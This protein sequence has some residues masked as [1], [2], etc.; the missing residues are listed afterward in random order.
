MLSTVTPIK[1]GTMLDI[2]FDVQSL[3]GHRTKLLFQSEYGTTVLVPFLIDQK[4][5][6]E[7]T[8]ERLIA[9]TLRQLIDPDY[10]P[11]YAL[12]V[13]EFFDLLKDGPTVI[14]KEIKRLIQ[15]AQ[16]KL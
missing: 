15:T 10:I 2:G 13:S 1:T 3:F 4:W 11:E 8:G 5:T 7:W 6:L 16:Q 12:E 14:E 9:Y